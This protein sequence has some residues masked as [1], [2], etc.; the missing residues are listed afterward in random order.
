MITDKAQLI[1]E[2][3]SPLFRLMWIHNQDEPLRRHFENNISAFHIG[4]GI[5]MT[6][7]HNL[8][9]DARLFKSMDEQLF[10]KEIYAQI[11][12]ALQQLFNNS[13]FFD[14]STNKRYINQISESD[15]QLIS[16]ELK[17][18]RFDTRYITLTQKKICNP[19]LIIQ[20]RT[21]DFYNDPALTALF[22]N[23]YLH[24]PQLER[25]TFLVEV[26]LI[27]AFY[28]TDLAMYKIVNTNQ[29]IIN[30]IP[31]IAPNFKIFDNKEE[32]YF[33]LQ[34][35]PVNN[36]GRLLN[37]AKIE[38]I[39]D[40][41][42]T[43][44]DQIGGNYIVDGIRYLIKGYFRFGSSGA[45]YIVFDE[46]SN[47]FK[48]N[49]VQSEACPIQ[50]SINNNQHGNFQYINAIATPLANIKAAIEQQISARN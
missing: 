23:R 7:A 49:A 37:D 34:S 43:F 21:N 38:G 35:A 26:E 9:S 24:E 14:I 8:K 6:A 20:F 48:V 2:Q 45:P 3:T 10:Q 28:S 11:N 4:N 16:N 1:N 19:F 47:S 32:N 5:I 30:K 36:L 25:H 33:C 42:N 17:R 12:P 13:F 41:W 50:L 44:S 18:I 40:H 22:V 29:N 15:S 31:Y 39:L 27:N 46:A